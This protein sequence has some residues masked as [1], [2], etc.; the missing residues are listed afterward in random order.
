MNKI[1]LIPAYQPKKDLLY[2]IIDELLDNNYSIVV[3]DDGSGDNF[4]DV[5]KMLPPNV[6]VLSYGE[7]HG[8]GYAIKHGLKYIKKHFSIDDVVVTID[9][10]GQHK[11]SDANKLITKLAKQ[12]NV[13]V[14]GSRVLSKNNPLRSRIGNSLVKFLFHTVTKTKINDTQTGLRAF[15]FA[16]IDLLISVPGNRY[17]YEM[18]ELLYCTRN[19][20]KIIEEIIETIYFGKNDSSHYQTIPD[21][22]R[23]FKEFIIFSLS[24]LVTSKSFNTSTFLLISE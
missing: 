11:V 13:L 20:I 3:V 10:D 19:N 22:L 4:K 1:A 17:E 6:N 23:I 21:S 12:K 18:N 8:K 16:L 24:S 7:N 2:P 5:F 9:S 14:L 15:S